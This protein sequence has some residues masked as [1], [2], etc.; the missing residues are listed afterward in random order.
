MKRFPVALQLYSVRDEL[1]KDYEATLRKV[2]A[3]GYDGVELPGLSD[4]VTPAE[5]KKLCEEI[6]LVPISSHVPLLDMIANPD[7][8]KSFKEI[9]C[10]YV[11]IPY[12]NEDLRPGTDG[13]AKVIDAAKMLSEKAN[14]LDL[15]ICYHNHD[16][17]FTKIGD[18]YAIDILY[19]EVPYL[20]PEFDICWVKVA[21]VDPSD[22]IRKYAGRQ[23]LLHLKDYVGEQCENMYNLIGLDDDEEKIASGNFEF[24]P[25]GYGC[26]DFYSILNAAE[27]AKVEWIIIEQDQPSIGKTPLECAELGV[28]YINTIN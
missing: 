27:D 15:K 24:R 17:E 23:D 25:I 20:Q 13:F 16:F 21:G 19:N 3:M 5:I 6:G 9:G 11:V 14:E 8:I 22:Y 10:K 28:K 7:I 18:E 2:K 12:L 26:Q 1:D 4:K